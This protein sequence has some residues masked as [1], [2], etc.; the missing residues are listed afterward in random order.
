MVIHTTVEEKSNEFYDKLRRRVYT[1]PKSYLDLI[2]LYISS[3]DTKR[4]EA[5]KSKRRLAI[6]L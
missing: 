3:L 6:G 5:I 4:D 2:Q 1:T